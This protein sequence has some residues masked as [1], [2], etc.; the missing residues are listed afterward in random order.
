MHGGNPGLLEFAFQAEIEVGRVYAYEYIGRVHDKVTRKLRT[1][2]AQF[3]VMTQHLY[4]P[5]HREFF[6][7]EQSRAAL[8]QHARTRDALDDEIRRPATQGL[9]QPR[10]QQIT[11]GLASYNAD[12]HLLKSATSAE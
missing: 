8:F 6:R 10:T 4:Q 9:N 11:L 5:H 3:A 7:G 12:A 1:D 2:G